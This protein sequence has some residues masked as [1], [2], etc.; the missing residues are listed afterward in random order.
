MRGNAQADGVCVSQAAKSPTIYGNHKLDPCDLNGGSYKKP[1]ADG[2]TFAGNIVA[3]ASGVPGEQFPI[4]ICDRCGKQFDAPE[5]SDEIYRDPSWNL[6][7]F[8]SKPP[9]SGTH[10][11]NA[12]GS[13]AGR[14]L[15]IVRS[16]APGQ[17][18]GHDNV[19][20]VIPDADTSRL[21]LAVR[22][23]R[24]KCGDVLKGMA[25]FGHV[26]ERYV[27]VVCDRASGALLNLQTGTSS[28]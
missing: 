19:W 26:R 2:K 23:E 28:T 27:Y 7:P 16:F 10:F 3:M 22:W 8:K 21:T 24:I 6:P 13:G 1:R 9:E 25:M 15:A 17:I 11:Y 4:Y 12:N 20:E 18:G 14:V 5:S